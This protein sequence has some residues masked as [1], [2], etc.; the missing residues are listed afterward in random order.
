MEEK[1]TKKKKLTLSISSKKPHNAP[2]YV[3]SKGKTS[4]VIEKKAPRRWSEKK[5]QSRDNRD[6]NANK[7]KLANDI[8]HKKTA[9]NRNIHIRKI[10]EERATNRFKNLKWNVLD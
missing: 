7:V 4:V 10:A 2:H 1:K 3:Q 8:I 9:I 5:F 6:N